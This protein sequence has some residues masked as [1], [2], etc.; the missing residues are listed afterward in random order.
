MLGKE[1]HSLRAGAQGHINGAQNAPLA[2]QRPLHSRRLQR[3]AARQLLARGLAREILTEQ[4]AQIEGDP[5][6]FLKVTEAYWKVIHT[7][8]WQST[9]AGADWVVMHSVTHASDLACFDPRKPW[10]PQQPRSCH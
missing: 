4:A 2:L 10:L 3:K 5:L 8:H 1:L 9:R 7:L 6:E